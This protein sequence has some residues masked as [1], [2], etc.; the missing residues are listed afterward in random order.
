[1][2]FF[3]PF[4]V[5]RVLGFFFSLSFLFYFIF[6]SVLQLKII[7]IPT[8]K[9]EVPRHVLGS[10]AY[11]ICCFFMIKK[12]GRKF[13]WKNAGNFFLTK[14]KRVKTLNWNNKNSTTEIN[15]KC[16]LIK[17]KCFIKTPCSQNLRIQ[18]YAPLKS[19]QKKSSEKLPKSQKAK[20]ST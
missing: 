10:G 16:M 4:Q 20:I 1:M 2:D 7:K 19:K 18:F 6:F 9:K 13:K 5:M 11:L 15:R 3:F 14:K 12:Y 17:K 8:E